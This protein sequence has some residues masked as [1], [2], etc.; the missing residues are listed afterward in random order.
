M[1][2]EQDIVTGFVNNTGDLVICFEESVGKEINLIPIYF[3][4]S[5]GKQCL[6]LWYAEVS[7]QPNFVYPGMC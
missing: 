5:N 1:I 6:K 7:M 4:D 3:N 2:L